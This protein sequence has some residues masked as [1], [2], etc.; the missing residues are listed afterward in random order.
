MPS[1]DGI[2]LI[3]IMM[4]IVIGMA[5]VLLMLRLKEPQRQNAHAVIVAGAGAAY[6]S[7][8]FG[9]WESAYMAVATIVAYYGLR[10]YRFIAGCL[11]DGHRVGR[12]ASSVRNAHRPVRAA[13]VVRMRSVRCRNRGMVRAGSGVAANRE[14][15]EYEVAATCGRAW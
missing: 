13:V 9:A 8:G 5:F 4:P 7:G 1:D 6:L 2:T 14:A 12:H 15:H 3:Q 11:T 10:S